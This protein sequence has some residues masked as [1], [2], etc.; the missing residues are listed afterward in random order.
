MLLQPRA[1]W[2]RD[3]SRRRRVLLAVVL[4]AVLILLLLFANLH[5]FT[6]LSASL[7]ERKSRG[8]RNRLDELASSLE[9]ISST[10]QKAIAAAFRAAAGIPGEP[11]LG[12]RVTS[13]ASAI[14]THVGHPH[15]EC[16]TE[17][18]EA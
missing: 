11:P 7:A 16:L 15:A 6:G 12:P 5:L 14:L 13:L 2:W 8:I 17:P 18:A 1:R 10:D 3:R 4:P 9:L